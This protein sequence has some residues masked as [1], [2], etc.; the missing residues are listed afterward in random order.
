MISVA[1]ALPAPRT[2]IL[3]T[4]G[5]VLVAEDPLRP[6]D[7][8]VVT[9]AGGAAGVLEATELVRQ[10]IATRVAVFAD[11]A[12]AVDREFMR[13]GVEYESRVSASLR[14]LRSLGVE[15]IEQIPKSIAGTEEEARVLPVW[16]RSQRVHSVVVVST[17]DHSRRLRRVFGRALEGFNT[18]VTI[19][20]TRYSPFD[21]DRWW[22]SRDGTRTAVVE[23]Q[24]LLL[25]FALH[26]FS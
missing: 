3:R 17:V 12:D 22:Q 13:R 11:P 21:P 9:A 14:L 26:P 16:C 23:L 8:I 15:T 20:S 2:A 25:D 7:V 24:K 18:R 1:A 5:H 10:G 4:A 6:V 19:R